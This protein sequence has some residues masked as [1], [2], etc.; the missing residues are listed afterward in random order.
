MSVSGQGPCACADWR[1]R[2]TVCAMRVR[3]RSR[4]SALSARGAGCRRTCAYGEC[5]RMISPTTRPRHATRWVLS[6]TFAKNELSRSRTSAKYEVT[7]APP[8]SASAGCRLALPHVSGPFGP[9]YRGWG[10]DLHAVAWLVDVTPDAR[11]DRADRSLT[12]VV[13]RNAPFGGGS[14]RR[15]IREPSRTSR[16]E[17]LPMCPSARSEKARATNCPDPRCEV[18]RPVAEGRSTSRSRRPTPCRSVA[19]S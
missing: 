2:P 11:C 3:Q 14:R 7:F 12:P 5:G 13:G 8:R 6:D 19:R 1:R 9:L 16:C 18:G 4:K 10:G 17:R 15:A